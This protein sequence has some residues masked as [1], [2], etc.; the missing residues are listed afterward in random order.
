MEKALF[1]WTSLLMHMSHLALN[2]I[3]GQSAIKTGCSSK[4]DTVD[5]IE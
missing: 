3:N 2:V 1:S 4:I 5:A